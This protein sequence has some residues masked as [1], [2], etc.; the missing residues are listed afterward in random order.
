MTE[1]QYPSTLSEIVEWMRLLREWGLR[2]YTLTPPIGEPT[3]TS[4]QIEVSGGWLSRR[5]SKWG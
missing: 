1:D 5:E 4:Y 2:G 3:I